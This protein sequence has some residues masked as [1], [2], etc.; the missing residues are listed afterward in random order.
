MVY[1]SYGSI[2]LYDFWNGFES[3]Q[4]EFQVKSSVS[5]QLSDNWSLGAGLG[6]V[7]SCH[8]RTTVYPDLVPYASMTGDIG[9]HYQKTRQVSEKSQAYFQWGFSIVNMGRKGTF[10][11]MFADDYFFPSSLQSGFLWGFN[12]TTQKGNTWRF[13][14]GGQLKYLLIPY[15]ADNQDLSAIPGMIVSLFEVPIRYA[16]NVWEEWTKQMGFESMYQGKLWRY[17]FRAGIWKEWGFSTYQTL[18]LSIGTHYIGK[19][20]LQLDMAYYAPFQPNDPF[21]N[22]VKFTL[23]F[24]RGM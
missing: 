19:S 14:V 10:G 23:N 20:W 2:S 16:T 3:P 8:I 24:V 6:Y 18:G 9:I 12:Q 15:E 7:F 1:Y 17:G 21:Q 5:H 11:E 13:S 4:P 22:T